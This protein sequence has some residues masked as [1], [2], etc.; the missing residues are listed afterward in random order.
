MIFLRHELHYRIVMNFK[1]CGIKGDTESEIVE[2]VTELVL[3]FILLLNTNRSG[4]LL[5]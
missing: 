1:I 3:L 2:R 5:Y 4:L